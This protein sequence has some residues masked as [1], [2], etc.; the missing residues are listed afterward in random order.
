MRK[1]RRTR[2]AS[3]ARNAHVP[4]TERRAMNAKGAALAEPR[5]SYL[6]R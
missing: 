6:K 1:V 2:A 4:A 5:L 3:R